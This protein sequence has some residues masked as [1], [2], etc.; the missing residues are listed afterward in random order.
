[1]QGRQTLVQNVE[2]LAHIATIVR[3]GPQ[4]FRRF[5]DSSQPG[6]QLVTLTGA[7][8]DPGRVVELLRPRTLGE[9]LTRQ[10]GV[11]E[12]PQALL[13]GGYGGTFVSGPA[14]MS[15]T[16][17]RDALADF[18]ASLGCGLVG[19]VPQ[20]VCG[21]KEA[22]GVLRYLASQSAGQCG[23]CL[24]GLQGLATVMDDL[25]AG[26]AKRRTIASTERRFFLIEGRGACSHPDAA[27]TLMRSALSVFITR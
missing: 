6:P 22:A 19:V 12:M 7:V 14:A 20:G 5:G 10:G 13:V 15:S 24:Y 11:V 27:V 8:K 21:L 3:F 18:G 25:V 26:R 16:F 2:T 9:L 1:V 4:A 23:P 17:T